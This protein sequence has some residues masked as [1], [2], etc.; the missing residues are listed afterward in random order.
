LNFLNATG[1][2]TVSTGKDLVSGGK[3][4]L[5]ILPQSAKPPAVTGK[6]HG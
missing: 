6:K 1:K 3:K 4:P 5:A 2:K